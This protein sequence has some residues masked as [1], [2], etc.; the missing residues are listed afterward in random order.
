MGVG[1]A[2]TQT[3]VQ[4]L[5]EAVRKYHDGLRWQRYVA[6]AA[7][8]SPLERDAFLDEREA[9]HEQL[10]INHYEITRMRFTQNGKEGHVHVKYTWYMDNVGVI[11]KTTSLQSWDRQGNS[12]RLREE[13]RVRGESMPGL[14]EDSSVSKTSTSSVPDSVVDDSLPESRAE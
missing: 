14:P 6:S 11:N 3:R 9:L 12:W 13:H 10:R 7:Y 4:P 8:I 5:G 1:C 2:G